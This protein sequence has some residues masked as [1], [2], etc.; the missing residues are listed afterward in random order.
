MG[1][2]WGAKGNRGRI[3][4]NSISDYER[5]DEINSLI[6]TFKTK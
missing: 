2:S 1:E 6:W 5:S 4:N 3:G